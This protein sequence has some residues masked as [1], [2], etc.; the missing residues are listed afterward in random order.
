MYL[1]TR[2][3][4]VEKTGYELTNKEIAGLSPEEQIARK[5]LMLDS[6]EE[7]RRLRRTE[8]EL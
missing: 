3:Q 8:E 6:R 7:I 4:R 1:N 5:K 2:E